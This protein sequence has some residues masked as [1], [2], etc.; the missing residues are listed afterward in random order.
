M[1]GREL[2]VYILENK[3]EDVPIFNTKL[4][5]EESEAAV[6]L[7]VGVATIRAWYDCGMISGIKVGDKL[8]VTVSGPIVITRC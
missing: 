3:L 8:Y 2:I 7:N 5:M 1:T 4:F 6:T